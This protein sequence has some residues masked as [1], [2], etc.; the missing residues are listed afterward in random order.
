MNLTRDEIAVPSERARI[1]EAMARSCAKRGYRETSIDDVIADADVTR[2]DFERLFGSKEACGIAAVE[3]ILGEGMSTVSGNYSMDISEWESALRALRALLE[4]FAARPAL[5]N[6][7]FIHSRQMMPEAAFSSYKSGFAILTAMLDRL[8]ADRVGDEEPPSSAA[9]AAIG[10][11]EA[12]VRREIAGGRGEQLLR[13]LPG[14]VYG[15]TVAFL[16]QE[17]ALRLAQRGRE[18]LRGTAGE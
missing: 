1:I 2:S 6:L 15:G 16:G 9:R 7:A 3:T 13:T 5:A 18:L 10:G 17:E 12:V 14:L 4:L 8:R 11:G